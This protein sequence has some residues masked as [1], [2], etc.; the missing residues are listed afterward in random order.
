MFSTSM[1]HEK[2]EQ[3]R[4]AVNE[5]VAADNELR[6]LRDSFVTSIEG[7]RTIRQ[8][9]VITPDDIKK[10]DELEKKMMDLFREKR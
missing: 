3:I 2:I 1:E 6:A 10:W 9:K 4:K 7:N 8:G 5:F